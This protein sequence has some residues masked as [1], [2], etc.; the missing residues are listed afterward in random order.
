MLLP[1]SELSIVEAYISGDVD[2]EGDLAKTMTI[3]DT[4][5]TRLRRPSVLASLARDLVALP[6]HDGA[7][8]DV[9]E[10]RADD[11]VE[12][13][14]KRHEAARD[15][16]AIQYHYDV[17]NDFYRLWLD[18]RMVYSCAYFERSGDTLDDAQEAKLDLVCRKLRLRE[19]ERFLDVGSGWGALIMHAARHYGVQ[20]VGITLS[21]QQRSLAIERIA[22]A[23][24]DRQC[25]VELR[26]YRDAPSLGPFDKITSVGMVEHVGV[27]RLGDYFA[28]IAR[29]LA[30]GG[31]FLNHGIVRI[32][33]EREMGWRERLERRLWRRDAFIEK[34]VF[35]DGRLVP[36]YA[37][38]SAAENAG[39]ETRDVESLR[40]HYAMTLRHWIERL[41]R[42]RKEA[43]ELVGDATYRVW[44]LYMTASMHGFSTGRLNVLQTLLAKPE[45]GRANLPM[46]REDLYR[47]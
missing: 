31:L 7:R 5:N 29:A 37:L 12:A 21:E 35:P 27:E 9:R 20:A 16:A 39:F 19:G 26:D 36:Y 13:K 33:G 2:V 10:Q 22:D 1:P 38:V 42:C 34:Y 32:A 14:G 4:I 46:T 44:R 30:P 47:D 25:H 28:S 40:E 45:N 15:R 3:A 43:T 8:A 18:E 17:G 11:E 6:R 24:L 41:E 23:G